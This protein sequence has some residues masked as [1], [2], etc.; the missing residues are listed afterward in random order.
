MAVDGPPVAVCPATNLKMPL[1]EDNHHDTLTA[2]HPDDR[3]DL[4]Q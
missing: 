2:Q 4:P 1:T 3:D